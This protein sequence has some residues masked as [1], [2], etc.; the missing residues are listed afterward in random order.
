MH[1]DAHYAISQLAIISIGP[2]TYLA[3]R[4]HLAHFSVTWA[5][6]GGGN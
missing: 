5:R 3:T 1:C 2:A 4:P 6:G